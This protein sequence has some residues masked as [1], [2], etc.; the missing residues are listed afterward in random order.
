[1]P[2]P[3]KLFEVSDVV[4][5]D[6]TKGTHT[7]TD[8]HTHF[9]FFKS[10][11]A[12]KIVISVH[13]LNV[14]VHM[15]THLYT[16]IKNERPLHYCCNS[17][18]NR[19]NLSNIQCRYC[20]CCSCVLTL[21]HTTVLPPSRSPHGPDVGV[22]NSRRLCAVYYNKSP[23]FEVIHGLLDRTMQLLEVKP[24]RGDGYHIQAAD[25]KELGQETTSRCIMK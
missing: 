16:S 9:F 6:E 8:T 17:N 5:K 3:L 20:G 13:L 15:L 21:L 18:A 7:D 2:L 12:I 10:H 24:A 14:I 1:M 22:R 19:S 23:G 4:L 11:T 25:G